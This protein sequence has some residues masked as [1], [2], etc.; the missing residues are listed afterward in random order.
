MPKKPDPAITARNLEMLSLYD[1]CGNFALV[2]RLFN[3]NQKTVIS[4]LQKLIAKRDNDRLLQARMDARKGTEWG[5]FLNTL[6]PHKDLKLLKFK[7]WEHL[8]SSKQST[9]LSLP[10]SL[11]NLII[12]YARQNYIDVSTITKMLK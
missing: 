2:A 7:S 12:E 5:D 10:P 1:V 11:V 8:L 6:P 3:M 4:T 9:I